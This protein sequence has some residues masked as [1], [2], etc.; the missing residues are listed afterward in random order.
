MFLVNKKE[1]PKCL[2]KVLNIL[3]MHVYRLNGMVNVWPNRKTW[4]N[5]REH[6]TEISFLICPMASNVNGM[7]AIR[8]YLVTCL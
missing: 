8:Y 4:R 2:E 7:G 6:R 3:F 5:V 1:N